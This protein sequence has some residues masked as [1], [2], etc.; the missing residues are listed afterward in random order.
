MTISCENT[1]SENC[2]SDDWHKISV[3]VE[4]N[5]NRKSKNKITIQF[6]NVDTSRLG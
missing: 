5:K 3:T 4:K 6:Y 2:K 1:D